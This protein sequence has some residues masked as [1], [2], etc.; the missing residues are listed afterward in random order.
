MN[1]IVRSNEPTKRE[2]AKGRNLAVG[3]V[4]APIV[5][6]GGPA[7]ISLVLLALLGVTPP[8]AATIL[9]LGMMITL[10]GLLV[11]FGLSGYFLYRRS[12]WSSEMR[13]RMARH[14]IKAEQ[15]SWFK[16]ELRSSEKKALQ[17]IERRDLLL[18]DAYKETLASRLTATRI[19]RS[20][21]TELLAAQRRRSKMRYS[22]SQNSKAYEK[23]IQ[24]D[25]SSISDIN[26]EAK[27]MLD[28]AEARLQMIEAAAARGN[29][30]ADSEL[31]LK[32]LDARTRELPLALEAAVMEQELREASNA[33]LPDDDAVE[34]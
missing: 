27:V 4:A 24:D 9:F 18:A 31:A 15:L 20:S 14:G 2:L 3:A 19:V 10:A 8:V 6:A 32:K 16:H 30:L 17:N 13:E 29:S 11:G 28:E 23:Q 7:L 34:K 1:E 25:I 12:V 22:K 21:K 26:R 5:L 33:I